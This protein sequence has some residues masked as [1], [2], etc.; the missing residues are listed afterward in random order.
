MAQH[1]HRV[2]AGDAIVF[3]IEAAP[4]RRPHAEDFKIVARNQFAVGPLRL[5]NARDAQRDRKPRQQS[6]KSSVAVPQILV[7]WVRKGSGPVSVARNPAWP[8]PRRTQHNQLFR[9]FHWK[10]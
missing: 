2:R 7:H 6:S 10:K 9:L 1:N 5:S 4:K 8:W 3:L